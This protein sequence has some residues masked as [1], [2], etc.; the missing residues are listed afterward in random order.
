M[1]IVKYVFLVSISIAIFS[2]G[3][4]ASG[5]VIEEE[6]VAVQDPVDT[7][8]EPKM[9]VS[10]E[11][12]ESKSILFIPESS[13]LIP[14]EVKTKIETALGEIMALMSVAQIEMTE[15]PMSITKKFSLAEMMSEFDVAIVAELPEGMEVFGRIEKGETYAGK[16]LKTVHV[17]SPFKL[18]ATYDGLIAYIKDNGYEINGNSWE[19]YID[20]PTKV[21]EDIRRINIYFPV[22]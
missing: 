10:E 9:E 21:A 1:K 7:A 18:K 5:P 11:M 4:E 13:S 22:K 16:A 20:D 19:V 2:C 8:L 15:A 12:V 17:G 3:Q 14:A 6:L